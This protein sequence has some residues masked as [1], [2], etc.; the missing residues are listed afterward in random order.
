MQQLHSRLYTLFCLIL[1]LCL[2][3]AG[4]GLVQ[5]QNLPVFRIGILDDET[6]ALTRGARLAVEQLNAAG[7]V[8]GADGTVFELELVSQSVSDLDDSIDTLNAASVI[9]VLGPVDNN[10]ALGNLPALQRLNVPVLTAATDD[11]L[12][13]QDTSDQ[14][15]RIRAQEAVKGRALANYLVSEFPG[16]PIVTAQLDLE[17]T[18]ALIGFTT[19]L[20]AQGLAP[21][22]SFLLEAGLTMDEFAAEVTVDNPPLLVIYGAP[23]VA[24]EFYISLLNFPEVGALVYNRADATGFKLGF[25]RS[26]LE[27]IIGV[28]NWSYAA[29]DERSEQFI[30]DFA[31]FYDMVPED[32]EAAAYDAIF[33][34]AA[35]I[36]EP[37][38][39]ITNVNGIARYE[40]VQGILQPSALAAGETSDQVMI[41]QT[42][43]YGGQTVLARYDGDTRFD[44]ASLPD[45]IVATATPTATETPLPTA[46]PDG[47]IITIT[48]A[49][50][51]VRSGPGLNYDVIGQLSQGDQAQVVGA[52]VD[53]S[54][55]AINFRGQTGW[56]S[57]SILDIFGNTNTIP[58]LP[59]P[60]TPTPQPTPL[61][62]AT[63][64]PPSIA[65]I[66]ITNAVPNRLTT[67][68]A[69]SITVTVRNQGFAAAGAFAVATSLMPGN[70]YAAQNLNG[71]AAGQTANITLSGTL[72]AGATGSQNIVI[73]ADLND[74]VPEGATGEANNGN[75]IFNY[76]ADAAVFSSG[77]LTLADGASVSLD[78]GSLD[79][80][81]SGG[82]L[83]A[84]GGTTIATLGGFS[85]FANVHRDAVAAAPLAGGP[86]ATVPVGTMIAILTDGGAKYAVIE[87]TGATV[88]GNLTFNFRVYS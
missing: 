37:G 68:G 17:S 78:S 36:G 73:V 9:A 44:V 65:D 19:G 60:P 24:R 34:L 77:S 18:A 72:G 67:G 70:V 49:R 15:V 8:V 54:W 16:V 33:L 28:T 63:S 25:T 82:S 52:N 46:T 38:S 57:R 87:V 69:F 31:G 75:Y 6:E 35:A 26:Q 43:G 79:I 56:L 55:V 40:G 50:Q 7:G 12:I 20:E 74:Q 2:S 48:S 29:P 71:L 41:F 27:G 62:T 4:A 45:E 32:V 85:N 3:I 53:L 58:I 10:I 59:V 83:S 1:I 84:V 5:A 80:M 81:W 64:L 66:V 76:L 86:I 14:L 30:A 39:L 51:N 13:I 88:G 11:T 21:A 61:P 42:N 23:D 47:V 22:Q